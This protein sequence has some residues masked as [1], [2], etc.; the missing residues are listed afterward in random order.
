[1]M[2]K[3]SKFGRFLVKDRTYDLVRAYRFD[4]HLRLIGC[5]NDSQIA[6]FARA[7]GPLSFRSDEFESGLC[8]APLS[9]YWT[10]QKW[11]KGLVN[12]LSAYKESTGERE[13]LLEFIDAQTDV[14]REGEPFSIRGLKT[15]LGIQGDVCEWLRNSTLPALAVCGRVHGFRNSH[16]SDAP[17]GMHAQIE[18]ADRGRTLECSYATRS[19][20]L[21]GLVRRIYT[22]PTGLLPSVPE[23]LPARDRTPETVLLVRM[24][25]P[26]R[27]EGMA[28]EAQETKGELKWL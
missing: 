12:L 20:S 26:H 7:W 11:L 27:S 14:S 5:A 6:S 13:A 9:G 2:Y 22:A 21:D 24:C 18:Q 23:N 19:A 28:A 4:P 15:H 1:M 3:F 16:R 10:F 17:L 8:S 25:S